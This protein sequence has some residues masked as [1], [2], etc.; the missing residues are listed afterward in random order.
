MKQVS[1]LKLM[2][3]TVSGLMAL[4]GAGG[5]QALT[6]IYTFTQSSCTSSCGTSP[7]GTVT[8]VQ[9]AAGE[10]G[11]TVALAPGSIFHDTKVTTNQ[12]HYAL[13]F[14][15]QNAPAIRLSDLPSA[16][17]SPYAVSTAQKA[18]SFTAAGF[19][20]FEYAINFPHTKSP[21]SISVYSF[22]ILGSGITLASIV[23]NSNGYFFSTDISHG[24]NTGNVAANS[25][26][27]SIATPE[28][29]TWALM[30]IGMAATGGLVRRRR[31]MVAKPA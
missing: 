6:N 18:G 30:L 7:Y 29:S 22:D 26:T 15:L 2:A 10:L 23:K 5:A 12:Q 24:G 21:P 25:F 1:G 14:N 17:T 4:A 28:P 16:F 9:E 3:A 27:T 31:G 19:G 11:V 13:V 8:V 20:S